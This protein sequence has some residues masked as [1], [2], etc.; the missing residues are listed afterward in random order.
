MSPSPRRNSRRRYLREAGRKIPPEKRRVAKSLKKR[1]Y[2][3]GLRSSSDQVERFARTLHCIL[4]VG[5]SVA[6]RHVIFHLRSKEQNAAY[7]AYILG[8]VGLLF[9]L[10][11]WASPCA[12]GG[13]EIDCVS[14]RVRGTGTNRGSIIPRCS[15]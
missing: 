5:A 4:R 9:V 12:G 11:S 7:L 6:R 8:V 2:L 13:T 3:L 10:W 14:A 1:R 15:A